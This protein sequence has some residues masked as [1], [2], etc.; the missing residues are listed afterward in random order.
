MNWYSLY[1]TATSFQI[2]IATDV[3]D[4][5]Y[6]RSGDDISYLDDQKA[7]ELLEEAL[8]TKYSIYDKNDV[9]NMAVRY[10]FKLTKLK[11]AFDHVVFYTEIFVKDEGR[12]EIELASPDHES[13][14]YHKKF[15]A[16]KESDKA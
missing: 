9:K 5:A 4:V 2:E 12:G 10:K 8:R 1:K 3:K 14:D 15:H 11:E 13:Y 6:R 16:L 7:K